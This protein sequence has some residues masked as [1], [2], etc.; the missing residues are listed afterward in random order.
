MY[1]YIY[2]EFEPNN[3]LDLKIE[4]FIY[5]QWLIIH[6]Y[7]NNEFVPTW[8]YLKT[9]QYCDR[10][11]PP[12][13]GGVSCLLCSLIKNPEKEDPPRSTW[14]AFFE[15]GPLPPGSWSGNIVNRKPPRR[16]V[17]LSI[18][19]YEQ[20]IGT[21]IYLKIEQLLYL[22]TEQ[23]VY[24]QWQMRYIYMNNEFVPNDIFEI[25]QSKHFCH[26][27]L[28]VQPIPLGVTFSNSVSKLKAQSW[29]VSF[30]W[31]VAKEKFELW[32]VSCRK[33]HPKW[34]WLY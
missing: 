5:Q 25:L 18:N 8:L 27:W 4:Q 33:R 21:Y 7:I 12:P 24:E 32:A 19:K 13:P 17:I 30:H 6:T 26:W 15:G 1:I 11:N 34:D 3:F 29:N 14:Y 2:D 10:K 23:Y 31:N 16:G 9:E 22:K 28:L 20:W